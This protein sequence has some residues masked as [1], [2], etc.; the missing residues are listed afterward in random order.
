MTSGRFTEEIMTA[1][2]LEIASR[3]GL[4]PAGATLLRLTNNAVFALPASDVVVR[5]ARSHQPGNRVTKGVALARWF[6]QVNAPTVRLAGPEQQPLAV[7]GMLAT[8]WRY[9]PARQ[10]LTIRDLGPALREFHRLELPPFQLPDWDPVADSR[11][12]L[13]DAEGLRDADRGA[14]EAWCDD[15]EPRLAQLRHRHP[16]SLVHGD[17]H[18]GNLLH[19]GQRVV[20]CDFDPIGTGPWQSDL[21]AVAV[22]EARFDRPGAHRQLVESYGYDVQEDPDWPL[23]RSARELKMVVAAVPL[24]ASGPGVERE[25]RTRLDTILSGDHNTRWTPFADLR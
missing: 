9:L 12:R 22:G 6:E 21:A 8:V 25:F 19:D 3:H 10:P 24:L 2:M 18:V 14:I 17:A 7:N 20:F 5:I 4:N 16:R 13:V 23:F 1:A 11:R 15:L